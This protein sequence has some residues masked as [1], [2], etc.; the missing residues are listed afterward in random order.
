MTE[1]PHVSF[2]KQ[3]CVLITR[4]QVLLGLGIDDL[5]RAAAY[6]DLVHMQV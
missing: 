6:G 4:L 1:V 5:W 2:Q 3:F